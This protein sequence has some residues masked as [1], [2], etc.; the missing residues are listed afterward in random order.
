MW[1]SPLLLLC[2]SNYM[3]FS[4]KERNDYLLCD[5]A[6]VISR[7][8]PLWFWWMIVQRI[9]LPRLQYLYFRFRPWYSQ[10]VY[11][12]FRPL[13]LHLFI[14]V[15]AHDIR[16]I[17]PHEAQLCRLQFL[18]PVSTHCSG[19]D[20]CTQYGFYRK[21]IQYSFILKFTV[22]SL[23]YKQWTRQF[24]TNHKK[25]KSIYESICKSAHKQQSKLNI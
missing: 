1:W 4:A 23:Q 7:V 10:Y 13:Y 8:L 21:E 24:T 17:L 5:Y 22:A 16:S 6:P 14:S 3:C 12:R 15:S 18:N 2:P 11:F 9:Q 19:L 25:I 20:V